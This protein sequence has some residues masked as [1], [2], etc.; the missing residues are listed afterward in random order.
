MLMRDQAS[1]SRIARDAIA[2]IAAEQAS[3]SIVADATGARIALLKPTLHHDVKS[4]C[5]RITRNKNSII[6]HS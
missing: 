2:S 3:A 6:N 5:T 1:A 4:G